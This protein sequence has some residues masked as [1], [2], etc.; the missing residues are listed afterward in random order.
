[1][2]S[3]S[4]S[5]GKAISQ[6]SNAGGNLITITTTPRTGAGNPAIQ[7]VGAGFGVRK[8]ART[9]PHGQTTAIRLLG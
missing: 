2:P 9:R 6:I 7:G 1:M 4:T 5:P 3:T 8:L